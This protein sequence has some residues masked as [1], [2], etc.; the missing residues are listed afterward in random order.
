MSKEKKKVK[1]VAHEVLLAKYFEERIY[2]KNKIYRVTIE[3]KPLFMLITPEGFEIYFAKKTVSGE[4]EVLEKVELKYSFS[5]NDFSSVTVDKF[6]LST[7]Y[8][9]NTGF[10]LKVDASNDLTEELQSHDIPVTFLERKWYNKILGFRSKNKWKMVVA[11]IGYLFIISAVFDGFIESDAEKAEQAAIQAE[12]AEKAKIEAD[13]KAK[14]EAER[15]AEAAEAMKRADEE[16]AKKK[17]DEEAAKKKADEE[18]KKEAEKTPQ[19]K[20]IE[21]ITGLFALKQAF[22]TGSYIKGDIPAGEYA[23]ISFSGSGKYYAEKD[24]AG[25]IIDN[26]NFDSFGYVYVNDA[27]NIE[28]Q[29]VLINIAAFGTLG[30]SGAKQIYEIVNNVQD[31]KDSAWYKVGVDI[32]PGQYVIESYGQGY[33]AVMAGPVGKSD[34]VD[35][36]NFN[37]RYTT[38]VTNG[39][40]LQISKGKI[41]Q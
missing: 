7:L 13:Q 4:E 19:Q 22:D 26:E 41:A 23:F 35:N 31:Y 6:A 20:M 34:I 17:A 11:V 33:V 18:A 5:W 14:K 10:T 40:Y 9:F 15:K 21:N 39:Q 37:G 38:N 28:T 36:E 3:N 2:K 27:G 30:V 8:Q 24:P 12:N 16:A 32:P 25:N 1:S 29:G